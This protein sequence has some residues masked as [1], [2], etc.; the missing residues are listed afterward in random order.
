MTNEQINI[1]IAESFPGKFRRE[2]RPK[3][4]AYWSDGAWRTCREGSI[5]TD[6]NAMQSAIKTLDYTE[7]LDWHGHNRDI[8]Y[9][10]GTSPELTNASQRA[11]AFLK[12]INAWKQ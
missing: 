12:A 10:D 2:D 6:L 5:C 3:Q 4:W 9:R 8:A 7:L 1:A 11:E